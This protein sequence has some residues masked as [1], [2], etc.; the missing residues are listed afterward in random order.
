M[1]KNTRVFLKETY[2]LGIFWRCAKSLSLLWLDFG[3]NTKQQTET[4]GTRTPKHS[5][6]NSSWNA[7]HSDLSSSHTSAAYTSSVLPGQS[8]NSCEDGSFPIPCRGTRSVT[9]FTTSSLVITDYLHSEKAY[10]TITAY[11]TETKH[12][13]L[14]SWVYLSSPPNRF[15]NV[16]NFP[17]QKKNTVHETI[18][19]GHWKIKACIKALHIV[20]K[21]RP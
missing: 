15:L 8:E 5:P 14:S 1:K 11:S 21:P 13:L 12:K 18:K 4:E 7:S 9:A 10:S 2:F 6:P 3:V 19:P 20:I 16:H 17:P